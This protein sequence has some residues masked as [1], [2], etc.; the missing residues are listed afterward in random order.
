MMRTK[1]HEQA[2]KAIAFICM[3][4]QAKA[5]AS[6]PKFYG[7]SHIKTWGKGGCGRGIRFHPQ[8]GP[9]ARGEN[10]LIAS[11][12]IDSTAK[13][14]YDPATDRTPSKNMPKVAYDELPAIS[15]DALLAAAHWSGEE[16]QVVGL[17]VL[18]W[19]GCSSKR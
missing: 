12:A 15:Y 4:T 17:H 6:K 11:T 19:I 8:G 5:K 9:E 18:S 13:N 1:S 2:M 7:V 14:V 3:L 10:A 16:R